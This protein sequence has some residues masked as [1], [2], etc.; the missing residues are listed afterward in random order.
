MSAKSRDERAGDGG[1]GAL[2]AE[3]DEIDD[4]LLD[5]LRDRLECCMRIAHHKRDHVIPMMQP[6]R[7]GFVQEKA[8]RYADA[9]CIDPA[10]LR[11]LYTLIIGETCRIED[12]IIDPHHVA[13]VDAARGAG[14]GG[15]SAPSKLDRPDRRRPA[16]AAA[17]PGR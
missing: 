3:L 13:P 15:I 16:Q 7:V 1:L 9:H 5:T 2:R 6:H 14:A 17:P 4:R 11:D 12:T 8:A 10:F